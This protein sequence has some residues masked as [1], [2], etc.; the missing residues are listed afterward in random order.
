MEFTEAK[1]FKFLIVFLITKLDNSFRFINDGILI[2][3]YDSKGE[4]KGIERE[5]GGDNNGLIFV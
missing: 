3:N 1:N 4:G 2:N 5:K